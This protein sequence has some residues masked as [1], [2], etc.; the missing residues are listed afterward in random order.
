MAKLF[1]KCYSFDCI[2]PMVNFLIMRYLLHR[3]QCKNLGLAG[4]KFLLSSDLYTDL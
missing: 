3:E 1:T 2:R 4:K